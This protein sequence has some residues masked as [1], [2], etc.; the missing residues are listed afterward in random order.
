[1]NLNH[2]KVIAMIPPGADPL[3]HPDVVTRVWDE[4]WAKIIEDV[5]KKGRLGKCQA[6]AI[7]RE[8]QGR[9]APHA[10]MLIWVEDCPGR[11]TPEW[12]DD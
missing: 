11:G 7:V 8:H 10:H 2:P 5:V 3:D 6:A 4:I 12:V 9:G 1:M